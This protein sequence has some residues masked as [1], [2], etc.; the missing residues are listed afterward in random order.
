M[1]GVM[2]LV[3]SALTACGSRSAQSVAGDP[4]PH[5]ARNVLPGLD[6]RTCAFA[7][8]RSQLPAF[9]DLAR[10]GTRGNIA[11]WGFAMDASDSVTISVRYDEQGRLSWVRA[12]Q[13]SL[14]PGRIGTLERLLMESFNEAGPMDWG[15]RVRVVGGDIAS[16]EPSVICPAEPRNTLRDPGVVPS[17]TLREYRRVSSIRGRFFPLEITINEDGRPIHV[18]MARSTGEGMLDHY[19][20]QWI[21]DTE[22]HPK[23]HDGIRLASTFEK[24]IYVPRYRQ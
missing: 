18:R 2:L 1:I 20:M 12:I 21:H 14:A 3:G 22:F 8:E 23:V 9:V 6:G 16:V 5:L 11:I 4:A 17:S 7:S 24:T 10:I 13:S 19:L 15:V